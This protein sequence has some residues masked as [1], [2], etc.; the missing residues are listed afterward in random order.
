[1]KIELRNAVDVIKFKNNIEYTLSDQVDIDLPESSDSVFL[2]LVQNYKDC[3]TGGRYHIFEY[4]LALCELGYLVVWVTNC[5]M[6]LY[7]ESFKDDKYLDNLVIVIPSNGI[8]SPFIFDRQYI[9][10]HI[11]GTPLDCISE[12]AK[13]KRL[14]RSCTYYQV[15][16]VVP[17]LASKYRCGIDVDDSTISFRDAMSDM[18]DA[19][20]F[21]TQTN[22]NKLALSKWL[23]VDLKKIKVI[24]PAV[25]TVVANKYLN[26]EKENRVLFISRFVTYKHPEIAYKVLKDLKFDGEFVMIGGAGGLAYSQFKMMAK[27]D[28]I[29]LRILETCS[30]DEKFEIISSSKLLLYPSD[31]EDFGMPPME[32]GYFGIPTVVF[33]NPTYEEVFKDELIYARRNDYNNFKNN[34][35]TSL[36]K[37][38]LNLGIL[39]LTFS[40]YHWSNLIRNMRNALWSEPDCN[41]NI[42]ILFDIAQ[43]CK[44]RGI[45]DILLTTP[46]IREFKRRFR[47]STIHYYARNK[48]AD[49]LI[50]NK[51]IDKIITSIHDLNESYDF[52]FIL[53]RKLEDYNISRNKEHR[54][55]SLAKLHNIELS[56]KHTI[57]ELSSDEIEK[58]KTLI[59]NNNKKNIVIAIKST[60]TYRNWSIEKFHDL[61]KRLEK[62]YNV[63]IADSVYDNTFNDLLIAKNLTGKLKLR[64]LCAMIHE[65]DLVITLDSASLHIA[66]ALDV[67]CIALFG[68]IPSDVRCRYYNKCQPIEHLDYCKNRCWDMQQGDC[69]KNECLQS[70]YSKCLNDIQVYEVYNKA[71][72]ILEN[73]NEF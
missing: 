34:V 69:L 35:K 2:F 48:N 21:W 26:N 33:R 27:K 52:H 19:D 36:R 56:N 13:Y 14:H 71:I 53:E 17:P 55:D 38:E 8:I 39:E 31:W 41:D 37:N 60:S 9:F 1:M 32:V 3:M 68:V 49:I 16:L 44:D 61:A 18:K 23:D 22:L 28:K 73:K 46:I 30:D 66:G 62:K 5:S 29:N 64:E 65:S 25:N 40:N 7:L 10:S 67:N 54:L 45:G 50:G 51:D 70:G 4:A 57:L 63:Y 12:A 72:Q 58:A 6:N 20:Y 11:I 47:H 42:T 24:P 59:L 15:V 43:G